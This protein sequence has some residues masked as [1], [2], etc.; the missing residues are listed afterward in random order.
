M[1]AINRAEK[2]VSAA[3]DRLE[4]MLRALTADAQPGDGGTAL[5]QAE[6]E[7][8]RDELRA[9]CEQLRRELAAA[10]RRSEQ[11]AAAVEQADERL[12]EAITRIESALPPRTREG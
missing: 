11:L 6:L 9:E 2:R 3:V 8:N 10:N 5:A 4:V 1:S 12:D 7:H